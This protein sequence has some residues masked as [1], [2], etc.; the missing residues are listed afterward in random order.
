M[1]KIKI[2][3]TSKK[4]NTKRRITSFLMI[5]WGFICCFQSSKAAQ[6]YLDGI[7]Y[8][9]INGTTVVEVRDNHIQ[10]Y[11]GNI[12]IPEN[13]IYKNT[14]FRVDAL[15]IQAFYECKNITAITLPFS[16]ITIGES[17]F[18][19]CT[20]LISFIIPEK[21]EKI[22]KRAFYRCLNLKKVTI[23]N[24][25]LGEMAFYECPNL[26]EIHIQQ[27]QPPVFNDSFDSFQATLY[28]PIGSKAA[29]QAAAGW[30]N[31]KNITEE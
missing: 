28:V 19:G 21:V 10:S 3:K 7:A 12:V 23:L 5:L 31:F 13:V 16:I 2:S 14:S 18:S 11:K 9:Y 26:A 29:Y 6:F 4:G 8:F 15:G 1:N 22:G 30:K 24:N 20:A 17:A 27:S 25:I